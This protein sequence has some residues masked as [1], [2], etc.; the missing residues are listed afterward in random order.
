ME[1]N[2]TEV[3]AVALERRMIRW[4]GRKDLGTGVLRNKTD[5]GEGISNISSE[6]KLKMRRAAL[7]KK[8]GPHSEE[9]RKK[10]SERAKGHKRFLGRLHSEETK[11]KCRLG[12]IGRVRSEETRKKISEAKR[13]KPNVFTEE[14]R[15]KLSEA[16]KLVWM[17]RKERNISVG[18]VPVF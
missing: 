18:N 16:T 6:T 5:G 14:T 2:L 15:K 11:E 7:G 3:G 4:Y 1:S 9:T 12:N 10:I 17:K 13:N 8:R